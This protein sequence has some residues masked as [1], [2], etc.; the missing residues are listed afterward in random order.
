MGTYIKTFDQQTE[1]ETYINSENAVLPNMS[2]CR[3]NNHAYFNQKP[4]PYNGHEY[5]DLGLPSGTLWAKC[6]VGANNET[7]YGLYFAWGETQ[8]YAGITSSKQFSLNDYVYY[9]DEDMTKYNDNDGLVTLE[10]SDDAA[11][12][13]MGGDWHM[14][15]VNQLNELTA[16]TN[17]EWTTLNGVSGYKF[18][19]QSDNT[20]YIFVPAA[21]V[22]NGG[23]VFGVGEF[24]VVW[25]QSVYESIVW[26]AWYMDF[27]SGGLELYHNLR[28]Y[29]RSVRGV[30]G[31]SDYVPEPTPV[32]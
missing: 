20:K 5:V 8:G 1:Y 31:E 28:Y 32:S 25:S 29:G 21:G 19:S 23:G 12:V 26:Y 30:L 17:S 18:T 10:A 27:Y 14:P 13:A 24:G 6:N 3:D 22:C 9:Q 11:S 2:Y 7:D 16:Y 15:S 4:D